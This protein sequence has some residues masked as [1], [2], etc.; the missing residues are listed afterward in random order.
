MKKANG[1]LLLILVLFVL[2][3]CGKKSEPG[4]NDILPGTWK[5]VRMVEDVDD[6]NVLN[7]SDYVYSMNDN[8]DYITYL[9][10]NDG[11]GSRTDSIYVI[12]TVSGM[13][14]TVTYKRT[15]PLKWQLLYNYTYLKLAI[16]DTTGGSNITTDYYLHVDS[17]PNP[18]LVLKDTSS[19]TNG[20]HTF[21]QTFIKQ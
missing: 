14:D 9:F 15:L 12:A 16:T 13:P 4:L 10:H 11:T 7:A 20:G 1:T 8:W 3:A 2:S 5:V 18:R 19:H 6:N 21:W 17:F